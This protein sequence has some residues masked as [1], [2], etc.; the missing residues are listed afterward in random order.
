MYL[1]RLSSFWALTHRES[2]RYSNFC[3][4]AAVLQ[5]STPFRITHLHYDRFLHYE[6]PSLNVYL[7]NSMSANVL[8]KDSQFDACAS[9]RQL[10]QCSL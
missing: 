9:K 2:Q 7:M 6:N 10:L 5:K 3:V 1:I 4:R 8:V